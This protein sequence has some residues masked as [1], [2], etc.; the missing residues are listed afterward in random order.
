MTDPVELPDPDRRVEVG[1][2]SLACDVRGQGGTPLVLVHG[3]TGGRIDFADVIDEL[4]DARQVVAHDHRGH[5]D[6]TNTGEA[7]GYT[8]QVLA[9][10]LAGLVDELGLDRF[11]LLGH[12]MGGL[13]VMRY[14]VDHPERVRSLVLMDTL[15]GPADL[16]LEWIDHVVGLGRDQGMG[17]VADL[18]ASF[19]QI[20][21]SVP[22]ERRAEMGVT[23]GLVRLSVGIEDETDLIEDLQ[24][25]LG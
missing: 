19:P 20:F 16:P 17:A 24:R 13:V 5:A 10:D 3:F 18:L 21:A 23:P 8:I 9:D 1:G 11:D 22:E 7:D 2:V 25:V 4:A 6:S 14:A 12:S 15:A